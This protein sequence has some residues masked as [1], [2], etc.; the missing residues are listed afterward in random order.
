MYAFVNNCIQAGIRLKNFLDCS[1]WFLRPLKV[2][3]KIIRVL[4]LVGA[5]SIKITAL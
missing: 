4:G 1:S 3:I 5:K 2:C